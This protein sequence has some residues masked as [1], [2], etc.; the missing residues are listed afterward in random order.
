MLHRLI[1]VALVAAL[2]PAAAIAETPATTS[3]SQACATIVQAAAD[4]LNSR[5]VADQT[6][7]K[8]PTSVTKLSCLNDFFNGTGLNLITNL[9]NPSQPPQVG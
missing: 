5:I 8:P 1:P 7:I 9:L 2:A 4:G 6:T 3:G